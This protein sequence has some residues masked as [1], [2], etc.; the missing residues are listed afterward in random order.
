MSCVRRFQ[1][2]KKISKIKRG[3]KRISKSKIEDRQ[4][5][6]RTLSKSKPRRIR[7]YYHNTKSQTQ[8]KI[9]N[10]KGFQNLT[11]RLAN[12]H[13]ETSKEETRILSISDSTRRRIYS[14]L[15]YNQQSFSSKIHENKKKVK[16]SKNSKKVEKSKKLKIFEKLKN[17]KKMK[18]SKFFG[19][20]EKREI[21]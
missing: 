16:K 2:F 14:L 4:E 21:Y 7:I 13:T 5:Q 20:R 10:Q 1:I 9:L 15:K 6:T 19:K 11:N 18:K 17:L 8:S 12:T 3:S